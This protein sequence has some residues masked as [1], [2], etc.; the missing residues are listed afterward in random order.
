MAGQDRRGAT[1][2]QQPAHW[3]DLHP[4]THNPDLLF[5]E[6]L[7]PVGTRVD[8]EIVNT[9]DVV[10]QG[11]DGKKPMPFLEF[12]GTDGKPR[13]KRLGV[14]AS[15]CKILETIFD[16]PDYL[17]WRGWITLVVVRGEYNDRK[18][19]ER[20]KQ[21]KIQVALRQPDPPRRPP[22]QQPQNAG[23]RAKFTPE[24]NSAIER[25]EE[26]MGRELDAGEQQ[27]VAEKPFTDEEIAA[28][29]REESEAGRG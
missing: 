1:P 8:V 18:L 25:A 3:R 12:R 16:T 28:I 29:K 4:R 11:E 21:N 24:Q 14:S 7:G 17:R 15:N 10:V 13:R 27:T 6:D 23:S 19:R 22:A 5:S 20:L 9:G 2:A 26:A